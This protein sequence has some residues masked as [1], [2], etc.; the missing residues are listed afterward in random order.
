[1]RA[2]I[3]WKWLEKVRDCIEIARLHCGGGA[4]T[5]FE[6]KPNAQGSAEENAQSKLEEALFVANEMVPKYLETVFKQCAE[7]L[8]YSGSESMQSLIRSAIALLVRLMN[9]PGMHKGM[10]ALARVLIAGK[11]FY[12]KNGTAKVR[13]NDDDDDDD[14]EEDEEDDELEEDGTLR[15]PRG[16]ELV[17][18]LIKDQD[19]DTL[20]FPPP[21]MSP[22]FNIADY[23]DNDAQIT[24]VTQLIA[25]QR[26]R[27]LRH[28]YALDYTALTASSPEIFDEYYFGHRD[29]LKEIK[30]E[31]REEKR[32]RKANKKAKSAVHSSAGSDGANPTGDRSDTPTSSQ[33][34]VDADSSVS[35][36]DVDSEKL[37]MSSSSANSGP[38]T[39]SSLPP[40]LADVYN[41]PMQ[42]EKHNIGVFENF[43]V[44]DATISGVDGDAEKRR[45]RV[46]TNG[47]AGDGDEELGEE[48]ELEED[49]ESD[50][51]DETVQV[52]LLNVNDE[53]NS[54]FFHGFLS[55]RSQREVGVYIRKQ[56]N[57]IVRSG[58]AAIALRRLLKCSVLH[59]SIV[60]HP[61][62]SKCPSLAA[63][64]A[65]AETSKYHAQQY[66]FFTSSYAA[67][68]NWT[69]CFKLL[70][71]LLT[72]LHASVRNQLA[73][74]LTALYRNV[75]MPMCCNV[76]GMRQD[77]YTKEC[78]EVNKLVEVKLLGLASRIADGIRAQ[79]SLEACE[80]VLA[81]FAT[82]SNYRR[83]VPPSPVVLYIPGHGP[84]PFFH[85]LSWESLS[86]LS[87]LALACPW[88]FAA[89]Q[90]P[91]YD[92]TTTDNSANNGGNGNGSAYNGSGLRFPL[93]HGVPVNY[94]TTRRTAEDI[95]GELKIIQAMASLDCRVLE[96]RLQ[97]VNCLI[98]V[99]KES[100]NILIRDH[101]RT[102]LLREYAQKI[103]Q[104]QQD[105][106][107]Y[108]SEIA[109][110]D[111]EDK[112]S[113]TPLRNRAPL[114][115]PRKPEHPLKVANTGAG[116]YSHQHSQHQQYIESIEQFN[117]L[118]FPV[119]CSLP[120]F[121]EQHAFTLLKSMFGARAH[122]AVIPKAR[123]ILTFFAQ[124]LLLTTE[125]LD[126][127][128]QSHLS[129]HIS[130]VHLVWEALEALCPGMHPDLVDHLFGLI[131]RDIFHPDYAALLLSPQLFALLKGVTSAGL[132]LQETSIQEQCEAAKENLEQERNY[133]NNQHQIRINELKRSALAK[134]KERAEGSE[135]TE[136][137]E[138][139]A[140]NENAGALDEEE[141]R[142]LN[143]EIDLANHQAN[144]SHH[145]AHTRSEERMA[146]LNQMPRKLYGLWTM[147]QVL[148]DG[149]SISSHVSASLT[150]HIVD[151]FFK[152]LC[153]WL[154]CLPLRIPL[155]IHCLARI[156]RGY[157]VAQSILLFNA[158]LETFIPHKTYTSY[159]ASQR[160][161]FPAIPEL[162][163]PPMAT[164]EL[165]STSP[166]SLVPV[167]PPQSIQGTTQIA[168]SLRLV[169]A[170]PVPFV[171]A[172]LPISRAVDWLEIHFSL[173]SLVLDAMR[174]FK[175][176]VF[177]K[178]EGISAQDF[179]SS[180]GADDDTSHS[181]PS[182]FVVKCIAD[183]ALE[184]RR[185]NNLIQLPYFSSPPALSAASSSSATI[186]TP[187]NYLE[188]VD[189]RQ[190]FMVCVAL[191]CEVKQLQSPQL[192][193]WWSLLT[194]WTLT[195]HELRIV[196]EHLITLLFNYNTELFPVSESNMRALFARL[197]RELDAKE[198]TK[199]GFELVKAF[200][201][202]HSWKA[203]QYVPLNVKEHPNFP[204]GFAISGDIANVPGLWLFWKIASEARNVKAAELA[205]KY[206][207]YFYEH[208][209]KEAMKPTFQ[210]A[211]VQN[212]VRI[213]SAD[214]EAVA[215]LIT[216]QSEQHHREMQ[217]VDMVPG[218][219]DEEAKEIVNRNHPSPA[220]VELRF[221]SISR[222]LALVR[223]VLS[224]N[225]SAPTT[226]GNAIRLT[227]KPVSGTVTEISLFHNDP[228]ALIRQKAGQAMEVGP[229]DV[230]LITGGKE[231]K[232]ELCDHF[233]ISQSPVP[234]APGSIIHI[235]KRNNPVNT[236]G[237]LQV[238]PALTPPE[239]STVAALLSSEPN[240]SLLFNV[241]LLASSL[242]KGEVAH[243]VWSLLMDLPHN[244]ELMAALQALVQVLPPSIEAND[245][246]MSIDLAP[247]NF[248]K[249][250]V[251]W[252]K[253][254]G[255]SNIFKLYYSLQIVES[256]LR[257]RDGPSL[258]SQRWQ[259][260]F[261]NSGGVIYLLLLILDTP[262]TE[263]E[264]GFK[265]FPTASLLLDLL[266]IF[267][268]EPIPANVN[269]LGKVRISVTELET[270]FGDTHF[271]LGDTDIIAVAKSFVKKLLELG[272]ACATEQL[273][274]LHTSEDSA[275][276]SLPTS[277]N[278]EPSS[279][280][281]ED[282]I[283]A[284]A[285]T[286]KTP[287]RKEEGVASNAE[288]LFTQ[289][290]AYV[291]TLARASPK[292]LSVITAPDLTPIWSKLIEVV[293]QKGLDDAKV[294]MMLLN[295]IS[296]I[297]A[298]SDQSS[299]T[300]NDDQKGESHPD[301]LKYFA[302]IV[303]KRAELYLGS[304]GTQCR[305]HAGEFFSLLIITIGRLFA[306]DQAAVDTLA[307][308]GDDPLEEGKW[309]L[310][311]QHEHSMRLIA[312]SEIHAEVSKHLK[313]ILTR[314]TQLLTSYSPLERRGESSLDTY[315]IGLI[316]ATRA[317][318][319]LFP[320]W[321]YT[322]PSI[323]FGGEAPVLSENQKA[324]EKE[325][326][327]YE[328]KIGHSIVCTI[329]NLLFRIPTPETIQSGAGKVAA[330]PACKTSDSRSAA[331][332]LLL[333]LTHPIVIASF[334]EL[335]TTLED[336][337][338]DSSE[339]MD[340]ANADR[341][342]SKLET[343][344]MTA[345]YFHLNEL[346]NNFI[347]PRHMER[348]AIGG[349]INTWSYVPLGNEK[350]PC[351]YVGL[352]NLA[353]TCYMNSLMQQF[354]MVPQFRSRIFSLAPYVEN[355]AGDNSGSLADSK[356]VLHQ[357][358]NLFAHLQESQLKYYDPTSFTKVYK[359]PDGRVMN[360]VV[361]MDAEEFFAGLLDKIE[362]VTK[363][364]PDEK[365]VR[366]FFGGSLWQQVEAKDCGH[367]SR[368]EEE[369][370]MIQV[371]VKGK[372]NLYQSLDAYVKA[373]ILD[374]DNKYQCS[375][376]NQ[377][378]DARKYACLGQLA[379]N[380]VFSLKRFDFDFESLTRVKV[381]DYFEFPTTLS[382]EPYTADG[383]KRRENAA[384]ESK[385]SAAD[386][387]AED[388]N[389]SNAEG[390]VSSSKDSP[391]NETSQKQDFDPLDY[392]YQLSGI[393]I[394]RGT[395][396][397]GHYYSYIKDRNSSP[398]NPRWY[399]FNDVSVESFDQQDIPAL[400]FGG[401]DS[402]RR[403]MK[404]YSAYMLFYTK[405]KVVNAR[406]QARLEAQQLSEAVP[407]PL[408]ATT[409]QENSSFL[410]DQQ[411]YDPL[412]LDF[413][414]SLVT[415]LENIASRDS[416]Y[417]V[418]DSSAIILT[419]VA[420]TLIT[421]TLMQMKAKTWYTRVIESLSRLVKLN[422]AAA[423]SL[424]M[425]LLQPS[426]STALTKVFVLC[427]LSDVKQQFSTLVSE[428]LASL[429]SS[430]SSSG[431]S[432][433]KKFVDVWVAKLLESV[434][435]TS[436]LPK[437]P[438]SAPWEP[439]VAAVASRANV[440]SVA[441]ENA[442]AR[443]HLAPLLLPHVRSFIEI[444]L[445]RIKGPQEEDMPK[446]HKA[447]RKP[448][449][450]L[451]SLISHLIV[452]SDPKKVRLPTNYI[453]ASIG[454]TTN[455][456]SSIPLDG[457]SSAYDHIPTSILPI[458]SYPLERETSSIAISSSDSLL[459]ELDDA[460][461]EHLSN[462]NFLCLLLDDNGLAAD[463]NEAVIGLFDFLA[464]SHP[465][466]ARHI[467][468]LCLRRMQ[469]LGW[470]RYENLVSVVPIA[471]SRLRQA[472]QLAFNAAH[473]LRTRLVDA[474]KK[475]KQNEKSSGKSPG[476]EDIEARYSWI[477]FPG[478]NSDALFKH[479]AVD[480]LSVAAAEAEASGTPVSSVLLPPNF[481]SAII[482]ELSQL[483][484]D[485]ETKTEESWKLE[486]DK[487]ALK[488]SENL[489]KAVLAHSSMSYWLG[490]KAFP[491]LL[492]AKKNLKL[493]SFW[494]LRVVLD[495]VENDFEARRAIQ[496]EPGLSSNFVDELLPHFIVFDKCDR[497]RSVA[498]R[499]ALALCV[500]ND[501]RRITW[502]S[503][504]DEDIIES[505]VASSY[506]N[507][508]FLPVP[509]PL[510]PRSYL[511]A[512]IDPLWE[513]RDTSKSSFEF[514]LSTTGAMTLPSAN[515]IDSIQTLVNEELRTIN[516]SMLAEQDASRKS[517]ILLA[518]NVDYECH[519][520]AL[521]VVLEKQVA[522]MKRIWSQLLPVFKS[523]SKAGAISSAG[524]TGKEVKWENVPRYR[525]VQM[526]RLLTFLL[527]RAPHDQKLALKEECF[528][529][530][531][532]VL[533]SLWREGCSE[534]YDA[535]RTALYAFVDVMSDDYHPILIELM[536]EDKFMHMNIH[537]NLDK[538]C[539]KP[540]GRYNDR[541][542]SHFFRIILRTILMIDS[543]HLKDKIGAMGP[544]IEEKRF[545]P[546]GSKPKS[547]M[548][549][550]VV[551][552]HESV[553]KITEITSSDSNNTILKTLVDMPAW[554]WSLTWLIMR[555]GL[556]RYPALASVLL[557]LNRFV[558]RRVA[559]S[560][561][562]NLVTMA[563]S[564]MET[565][566]LN[567]S[568][569]PASASSSGVIFGSGVQSILL[570]AV[571]GTL[572]PE[573]YSLQPDEGFTQESKEDALFAR[574][575]AT[576][577][578]SFN[579]FDNGK[580]LTNAMDASSIFMNP[581][582]T[583]ANS[584]YLTWIMPELGASTTTSSSPENA[585]KQKSYLP[586]GV[587]E[588]NIPA[589]AFS[590]TNW[591]S[592][593]QIP[594]TSS[595]LVTLM[596]PAATPTS[597][598]AEEGSTSNA[599]KE[600]VTAWMQDVWIL[601]QQRLVGA[602]LAFLAP[603]A[604]SATLPSS[605][606]AEKEGTSPLLYFVLSGL[607][608][609]P[610]V[611]A[612]SAQRAAFDMLTILRLALSWVVPLALAKESQ[613]QKQSSAQGQAADSSS[614]SAAE[615]QQHGFPKN[616]IFSSQ[617]RPLLP[618]QQVMYE[619]FCED[620]T[621]MTAAEETAAWIA[622][623]QLKDSSQVVLSAL[624]AFVLSSTA[625]QSL[626]QQHLS[627]NSAQAANEPPRS[628]VETSA[629]RASLSALALDVA[630]ALNCLS[631]HSSNASLTAIIGN[632][633]NTQSESSAMD[634]DKSSSSSALTT[635]QVNSI[636][637]FVLFSGRLLASRVGP[638]GDSGDWSAPLEKLVQILVAII[639]ASTE[640]SA[641]AERAR[642]ASNLLVNVVG[643]SEALVQVAKNV[644]QSLDLKNKL[645][646]AHKHIVDALAAFL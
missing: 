106:K 477:L 122:V 315:L 134:K 182:R 151:N 578:D 74:H 534:E 441:L 276:E 121:L 109:R 32:R 73:S 368:R 546:L 210:T 41:V 255:N 267:L 587:G 644:A 498:E 21:Y 195:K 233:S 558:M 9:H 29:L 337:E 161:D 43:T 46:I 588:D 103:E 260:A 394:H 156:H 604:S 1:M 54:L 386:A 114:V 387:S 385:S 580:Y 311:A 383:L 425:T 97:G 252:N 353:A 214:Y 323:M 202:Y 249:P 457:A 570:D 33:M 639:A 640:S 205:T 555:G 52:R 185:N 551:Q 299:E 96:R 118:T 442:S 53:A 331:F 145:S 397:S 581:Y 583:L 340:I 303:L 560:K 28:R 438:L 240:F 239:T 633:S 448:L 61:V 330:P 525:Y 140:E 338:K 177:E 603:S 123:D 193:I 308:A 184:E 101:D 288:L 116:F 605:P 289:I 341:L 40:H 636:A 30:R 301:A 55:K 257:P 571:I 253:L 313:S 390:A 15:I 347:I 44:E 282:D 356:A 487:E 531:L 176:H 207:G 183:K 172:H 175:A 482:S 258:E 256:L 212:A 471:L 150:R 280:E 545:T 568:C 84:T 459:P 148:S 147:L 231:L 242:E 227:L 611:S 167:D 480:Y 196:C 492:E 343:L 381:H 11:Q 85:L 59:P 199:A 346:V 18:S 510:F 466:W 462:D 556:E 638:D 371:E 152:P 514:H 380:L 455:A 264:Q 251:A 508:I 419:R 209:Q 550:G 126:Y 499:I 14:D 129:K 127:I 47:G 446:D 612:I 507:S 274:E 440:L 358:Q 591:A 208:P 511:S 447:W 369:T 416:S 608:A 254:L 484:S 408:F 481:T 621:L 166:L 93:I 488:A 434:S 62:W 406:A 617:H 529:S 461:W 518:E 90:S 6:S 642:L 415:R 547:L 439:V 533:K 250:K 401:E 235:M 524:T 626:A 104:Y 354:Y 643:K 111:I 259:T 618:L 596:L 113:E 519:R 194:Q 563:I 388:A 395:A 606:Y 190:R 334:E 520:T 382:V 452:Y 304:T 355:A 360:P 165:L 465:V 92:Y 396:D 576:P 139:G 414:S 219:T 444:L 567:L 575:S 120:R 430:K 454:A 456:V 601:I 187:F 376:C 632:D 211:F 344:G 327:R 634:Q 410:L 70:C 543:T 296:S 503:R 436:D 108:Q 602:A 641:D 158:I 22:D 537:V 400:A 496:S 504:K 271:S 398:E 238:P 333:T 590:I 393:V 169:G 586:S 91:I 154:H 35:S 268:I 585:S 513:E 7:E 600:S 491:T 646:A 27:N 541:T 98:E 294:R 553:N 157:S 245:A 75:F 373:D 378:V 582:K 137:A 493:A 362:M 201:V 273:S 107:A 265:R 159:S 490:H 392:E 153:D 112:N 530:C 542:S 119:H 620:A 284:V 630:E 370:L 348:A 23:C 548:D 236:T 549:L 435:S 404:A 83:R 26:I 99:A 218:T 350:A 125:H 609:H 357:L 598:H 221:T 470:E 460:T 263:P 426:S 60:N 584:S 443:P 133:I 403:T 132:Q 505:A 86:K 269:S 149:T 38:L 39:S 192:E 135:G 574:P 82:S 128:W 50:S 365:A 173:Q 607:Y 64:G 573:V 25:E 88:N 87:P 198:M 379:D 352:R 277:P 306:F 320:S 131:Q 502:F 272:V 437:A 285:R 566:P 610:S 316:S 616:A 283:N 500:G 223:K 561:R 314:M 474:L 645:T 467:L 449:G 178:E 349:G 179:N 48:E 203:S 100:S 318:I 293:F 216:S 174:T 627:Q 572:A 366:E 562:E 532:D 497:V 495:C 278:A 512:E 80:T 24:Q 279:Q 453:E 309:H 483:I 226:R 417:G 89:E 526:L 625:V 160:D 384:K 220:E 138:D 144:S 517:L 4:A 342:S 538:N 297:I 168:T 445:F 515:H 225:R 19:V 266:S 67:F 431:G 552:A 536:K 56:V 8:D 13:N 413:A 200:I 117:S 478:G 623:Q 464:S 613:Q 328:S 450:P 275:L 540:I 124:Q 143:I 564:Q 597:E 228:V 16:E 188:H 326:A 204:L 94:S 615:G 486:N 164:H 81:E 136:G 261:Y 115:P 335:K 469:E 509:T 594:T 215:P 42:S 305:A 324:K 34:Q 427:P 628:A 554:G 501:E 102:R 463:A 399:L 389:N 579:T 72:C 325:F 281:S 593:N 270:L 5:A 407:K 234:I 539:A 163:L 295:A 522:V 12:K 222:I 51:E 287:A 243:E 375:Q 110:R 58:A 76:E 332:T 423:G 329:G 217:V 162:V 180:L 451:A 310:L 2:E 36:S 479:F 298:L 364:T 65:P 521:K 155:L 391:A 79:Q 377:M 468:V 63:F 20:H 262:L 592:K 31:C 186:P 142:Q 614:S 631:P 409:W 577:F 629:F 433:A 3:L 336:D 319:L 49:E 57:F 224:S 247:Y 420:F 241:L 589:H 359:G 229:M 637:P 361:Q 527:I 432:A 412:Y 372:A 197:E 475:R 237:V 302:G 363:G 528:K 559:A 351:G 321:T 17:T 535:N 506:L 494:S 317:C 171:G 141:Q 624:H 45:F 246:S 307:T 516:K 244:K 181:I 345:A 95:G 485:S 489:A 189:I 230:R 599:L 146:Q 312:T 367:V 411:I 619:L 191:A 248:E 424:L 339:K 458:D 523:A 71:R 68:T 292:Y 78:E 290:W 476:L 206:I 66:P 418:D 473:Q 300:S 565:L 635:E 422:G 622:S 286:T 405:T 77:M 402:N 37:S 322:H 69:G 291:L 428:A 595:P 569:Y 472:R 429:L 232:A 374:G 544:K 170:L 213:L 10:D 130:I 421:E 105:V 557:S